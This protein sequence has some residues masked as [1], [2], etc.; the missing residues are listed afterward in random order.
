MTQSY[1]DVWVKD[2]FIRCPCPCYTLLKHD[3]AFDE[4]DRC[5]GCDL[6]F[7][8]V[9]K[10]FEKQIA[11][12]KKR[13]DEELKEIAAKKAKTAATASTSSSSSSAPT[14]LRFPTS[15]TENVAVRKLF[16]EHIYPAYTKDPAPFDDAEFEIGGIK[17]HECADKY[18]TV[19]LA[20]KELKD[21]SE[22]NLKIRSALGDSKLI[23]A[24]LKKA[25]CT[26]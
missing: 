7:I 8:E 17:N 13:V 10:D 12:T 9:Q 3:P 20:K 14:T 11:D 22:M 2:K 1:D 25:L 5:P 4:F 19:Y 15:V 16:E 24:A 18:V 21:R 23:V 6:H 26:V